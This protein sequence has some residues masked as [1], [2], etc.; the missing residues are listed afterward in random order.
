MTHD[1]LIAK[2]LDD[3]FET[4][5]IVQGTTLKLWLNAEP[6]PDFI[7]DVDLMEQNESEQK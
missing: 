1:E 2:L 3:G 7:T 5:W 4:G 6:I